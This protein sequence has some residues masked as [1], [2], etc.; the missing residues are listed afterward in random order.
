MTTNELR[1]V[2]GKKFSYGME[3]LS[4]A[5]YRLEN[6]KHADALFDAKLAFQNLREAVGKDAISVLERNTETKES[7]S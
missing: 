4:M 7:E 6:R 1:I 3:K 5:I 2:N